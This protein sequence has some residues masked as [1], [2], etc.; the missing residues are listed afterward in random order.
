MISLAAYKVLHLVGVFM[1]VISLG[2]ILMRA[3]SGETTPSRWR[4]PAAITHG[5]GMLFVLIGGFGMLARLGIISGWPAWVWVK[6]VIWLLLGAMIALA[7][8]IPAQGKLFWWLIIL[9]A[10]VAA[11]LGINKPF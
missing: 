3:I 5:V 4:M 8:R 9:L 6:L 2:G 1:I 10:G 7:K 11:W